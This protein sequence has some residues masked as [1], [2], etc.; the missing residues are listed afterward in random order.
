MCWSPQLSQQLCLHLPGR[1]R[2]REEEQA[3]RSCG[4]GSM[5]TKQRDPGPDGMF[6]CRGLVLH[7]G[8][9]P[10]SQALH[11]HGIQHI[12]APESVFGTLAA[13]SDLEAF[14]WASTAGRP[15]WV[16]S[17]HPQFP[18]PWLLHPVIPP[19]YSC[20]LSSYTSASYSVCKPRPSSTTLKAVTSGPC[21]KTSLCYLCVL[22]PVCSAV[23]SSLESD[24][25]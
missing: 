12:P 1:V 4:G 23:Y 13:P 21:L 20:P 9:F 24:L 7:P 5:V 11:L 18:L 10:V 2:V 6:L 22:C 16:L 15:S 8:P 25:E 14:L 3:V 17:V 19:A